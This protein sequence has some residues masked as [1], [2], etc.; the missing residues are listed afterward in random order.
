[1]AS[2]MGPNTPSLLLTCVF[3][4]ILVPF[5]SSL[6]FFFFVP[7][8]SLVDWNKRNVFCTACSRPLRSVWAGWKR[9]CIP[10]EPAAGGVEVEACS[11]KKGVHNFNYPRT[12]P[13]VIMVRP[14]YNF[15]L[16][17]RRR[18]ANLLRRAQAVVS[19]DKSKILLGRQRVWPAKFYSCLAGF[20]ESG[21]TVEEAV[22]R[23]VYEEAGVE[24]DEV[25]Y[26]SSQPWPYPSSLMIGCLAVAK[27][28]QTIR[29]DLDN[30]LEDARYFTREEVLSVLASTE[31]QLSRHEV[32][33]IDGKEGADGDEAEK[34]K[35]ENEPLFRMPPSTAIAHG[36]SRAFCSDR[37]R[38]WQADPACFSLAQF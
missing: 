20:I 32:A 33:K 18:D 35:D 11:S 7:W 25:V 30:E 6:S 10:A 8:Q 15:C 2:G 27:E 4:F 29:C 5:L 23:E 1:M 28:G 3:V 22:R 26:H 34:K 9:T 17:W 16:T 36:K 14:P 19:P 31:I 13:V 24:C 38:G 12:D 37:L 21:E